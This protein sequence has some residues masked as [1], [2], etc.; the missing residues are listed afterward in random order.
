MSTPAQ[1]AANTANARKSTGPR[2]D[3]GK[4]VSSRNARTHGL[5]SKE[6][7]VPPGQEEDFA[8]FVSGYRADLQP[9]GAV[10]E[11]LFTRLIHAAWTLRRCREVETRVGYG[12]NDDPLADAKYYDN[13]RLIDLYTRRA[14]SEYSKLLK[15]LRTL[16]TERQLRVEMQPPN[17]YPDAE[18]TMRSCSI[19]VDSSRIFS[20]VTKTDERK[21]RNDLRQLESYLMAPPPGFTH[22]LREQTKPIASSSPNLNPKEVSGA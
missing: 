3:S 20:E 7:V 16:Q 1:V 21:S 14:S 22:D 19:A 18:K 15:E 13:L 5:R 12:A 8:A 10:E 2:T 4:A 17:E 9:E 6:F 11:D